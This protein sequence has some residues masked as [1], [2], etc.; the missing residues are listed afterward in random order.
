M[1]IIKHNGHVR[2]SVC[3]IVGGSGIDFQGLR[4]KSLF[5]GTLLILAPYG[6]V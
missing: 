3:A 1:S 4:G 2:I 6:R 5:P